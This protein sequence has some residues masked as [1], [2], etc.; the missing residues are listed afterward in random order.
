MSAVVFK[1]IRI[2]RGCARKAARQAV[3]YPLTGRIQASSEHTPS[4][5][6]TNK[7]YKCLYLWRD[8]LDELKAAKWNQLLQKGVYERC[9]NCLPAF[10]V[11]TPST[12]SCKQFSICPFCYARHVTN[13]CHV[14][15]RLLRAAQSYTPKEYCILGYIDRYSSADPL[16]QIIRF[17][18][19]NRRATYEQFEAHGGYIGS[20]IEPIGDQEWRVTKR[21]FVLTSSDIR[22]AD[23]GFN[24]YKVRT[25]SLR[26]ISRLVGH[27]MKYPTSLLR[28]ATVER[29]V[30]LLHARHDNRLYASFGV[31]R[32]TI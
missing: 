16:K 3:L 18:I 25:P 15:T 1:G 6:A 31:F 22:T 32:K 30:E 2:P 19:D 21:G 7:I 24:A 14:I 23:Y 5:Q 4:Y 17:E 8:R 10:F 20:E 26:N 28:Y 27:I 13:L 29:V 11:C 12:R 9:L